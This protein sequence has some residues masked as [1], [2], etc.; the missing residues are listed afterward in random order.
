MAH[1]VTGR[2]I[3]CR[4]TECVAVCP[5]DCFSEIEAPRMVVI[6]PSSCID[7]TACREVCPVEA[8]YRDEDVPERYESFVELNA[9]RW[10]EGVPISDSIGPLETAVDFEE[11]KR[12]EE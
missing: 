11:I 10:A 8:I 3:G 6:D 1:V 5:C 9:I 12:R 2:C 4:Y 7:C